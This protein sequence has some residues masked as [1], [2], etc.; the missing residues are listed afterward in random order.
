MSSAGRGPATRPRLRLRL[1]GPSEESTASGIYGTIVAA[2]VMAAS[3]APSAL[4]TIV[5]VAVTLVTY[6]AAERYARL[7]AD[8][9]HRDRPPSW[10]EVRVQLAS[11]WEMVTVSTLPLLVLAGFALLGAELTVAVLAGLVCS[12]LMLCLTGWEIGR[13]GRL[14]GL[15]RC[16]L[17]AVAGGFGVLM[18]VLKSLL[19]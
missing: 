14:S 5:A 13:G 4:A 18:I 11:G 17:V 2:A 8:R 16:A 3:H 10:A 19:H 9:L 6:W 15:E 7:V 12:T 1:R